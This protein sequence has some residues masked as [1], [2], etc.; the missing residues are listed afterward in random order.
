MV[1]LT[2]WLDTAHR[3]QDD[4]SNPGVLRKVE[5]NDECG[6]NA[7]EAGLQ[8]CPVCI[9]YKAGV[10]VPEFERWRKVGCTVRDESENNTSF[11]RFWA[12]YDYKVGNKAR[13]EKKWNALPDGDRLLA[14]GA[15]A[16]YKR[17]ALD[18]K[19]NRVY[20]ETYIDQRRWENEYTN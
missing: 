10:A 20:P 8:E 12:A 6:R 19:Q 7:K 18:K 5:F 9:H 11:A 17:F 16:R 1:M 4:G 13:V 14:L 3:W 15:I 2:Y